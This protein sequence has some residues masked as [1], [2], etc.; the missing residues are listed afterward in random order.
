MSSTPG[1]AP[2]DYAL[3]ARSKRRAGRIIG[4]TLGGALTLLLAIAILLPSLCRSSET[5]NRVK[6]A[7]NLRQIG[8]AIV[9]YTD[10]HGG[11]Y[12]DSLATLLL[13]TDLTAECFFCPS[14]ND[15]KAPGATPA[16]QAANLQSPGHLSYI[17]L[18]SG[19]TTT[20]ATATTV[21]AYERLVDHSDDGTNILFG[22]GHVEWSNRRGAAQ[23]IPGLAASAASKPAN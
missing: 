5:A 12:P 17:Y 15:E 20:T 9:L 13:N 4:Y 16:E 1:L 23:I 18:G 14:S 8:Q 22:D 10:A 21:V 3:P 19:L 11:D 7:S 6:C 2:L